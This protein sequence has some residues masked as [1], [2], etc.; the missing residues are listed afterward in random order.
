MSVID[1]FPDVLQNLEATVAEAW[2]DHPQMSDYTVLT[3]YETAFHFYRDEMRGHA[4][5]PPGLQ[6]LDGE[7]FNRVQSICEFRLGRGPAQE[8]AAE[9]V[10]P[11][12]LDKL[13]ECLRRLM[14]SVKL[15]TSMAGRQGYLAFIVQFLD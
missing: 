3:A 12:P 5:K 6:G 2:R 4:P 8:A 13:V 14:K 11:I 15:H 9:K 10:T 1:D 7:V